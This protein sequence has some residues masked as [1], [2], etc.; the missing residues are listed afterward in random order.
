MRRPSA[1]FSSIRPRSPMRA[2][3]D[4]SSRLVSGR[5]SMSTA[6]PAAVTVRG[7]SSSASGLP[8]ATSR[9][10]VRVRASSRSRPGR[11]SRRPTRGPAARDRRWQRPGP[12]AARPRRR[13]AWPAGPCGRTAIR[14]ATKA[15]ACWLD[16]S[17][18]CT[19]SARTSTGFL[20]PP[21]RSGRA[22]PSPPSTGR[23]ASPIPCRTRRR[24]PRGGV[25]A[26]RIERLSTGRTTWCSAANGKPNSAAVPAARR[27][28]NLSPAV[29][30]AHSSS[31]DLPIPGKP[32]ITSA[33]PRA[34]ASSSS[35]AIRARSGSRP[36]SGARS[37]ISPPV[38]SRCLTSL[39]PPRAEAVTGKAMTDTS[40]AAT[41]AT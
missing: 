1:R 24:A 3:N 31:A 38:A 37:A 12:R 5:R 41:R 33:A 18:Q 36:V 21:R 25:A 6:S 30:A 7:S 8:P 23:A 10:S 4:R 2:A 13:A 34:V 40:P 27:T 20:P 14:R 17:I 22:R 15:S 32:R 26:S 29:A 9:I 35:P 39:C 11:G 28:W 19:S 16:G